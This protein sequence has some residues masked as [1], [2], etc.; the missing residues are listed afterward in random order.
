MHRSHGAAR[1]SDR[2][3]PVA[4]AKFNH[5]PGDRPEEK[6]VE[7]VLGVKEAIPLLF[8]RHSAFSRL[9]RN[10]GWQLKLRLYRGH[11]RFSDWLLA[12]GHRSCQSGVAAFSRV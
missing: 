9:H 6:A 7:N 5:V 2:K 11:D 4:T 1:G 3:S 8:A 12:R 10:L